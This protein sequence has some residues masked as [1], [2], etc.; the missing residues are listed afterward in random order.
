MNRGLLNLKTLPP[1]VIQVL[2]GAVLEKQIPTAILLNIILLSRRKP[3]GLP[4][5]KS[6]Q[7]MT[8]KESEKNQDQVGLAQV[9]QYNSDFAAAAANAITILNAQATILVIT[10]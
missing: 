1:N 8:S 3:F 6:T 10:T 2:S 7:I 9:N 5:E 4:S